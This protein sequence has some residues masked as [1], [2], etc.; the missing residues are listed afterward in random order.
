MLGA[1]CTRRLEALV[2]GEFVPRKLVLGAM[3]PGALMGLLLQT[4]EWCYK[5]SIIK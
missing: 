5:M 3:V 1:V 4:G 2:L